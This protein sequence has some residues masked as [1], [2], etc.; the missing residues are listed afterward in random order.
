MKVWRL[1]FSPCSMFNKL[2][3]DYLCLWPSTKLL[4]NNLLNSWNE[5]IMFGGSLPNHTLAGPLNVVGKALYMISSRMTWR[6][7][8]ILKVAIWSQGSRVPSYESK[9]GI[10]NLE[11]RMTRD[12]RGE[13]R[14]SSVDKIIHMVRSP[15]KVLHLVHSF[16]HLVYLSLQVWHPP[17]DNTSRVFSSFNAVLRPSILWIFPVL[18]NASLSTLSINFFSNFLVLLR[19]VCHYNCHGLQLLLDGQWWWLCSI[20]MIGGIS[21]LLMF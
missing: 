2:D 9:V 6:C 4:T 15:H 17:S 13:G 1:L 12:G 16:L 3:K 5:V 14:V 20:W 10:L 21:T 8:I 19:Q 18:L 11:G 7:M